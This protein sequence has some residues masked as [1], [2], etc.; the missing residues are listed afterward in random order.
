MTLMKGGKAISHAKRN[1]NLFTIELTM[2]GQ[3]I[4]AISKAM[5][6]MGRGWPTHLVSRNKR[7]RLW[8]WE[9]AQISKTQIVRASKLVE[10]IDQ[11]LA[12]KYNQLK[13][14]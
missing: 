5:I 12:Q 4:S 8:Y 14:L 2:L 9:L 7:I 1:H 13:Y 3:P 10:A 6:I 11:C